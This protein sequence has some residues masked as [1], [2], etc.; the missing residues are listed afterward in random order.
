MA[1]VYEA[2]DR[3]GRTCLPHRYADGMFR[4]VRY[5]SRDPR[6]KVRSRYVVVSEGDLPAI[7]ADPSLYV[8]MSPGAD[9]R[10]PALFSTRRVR[11]RRC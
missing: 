2:V 4:A 8:R 11:A 7:M 3:K 1:I 6:W 10:R 9:R 5:V